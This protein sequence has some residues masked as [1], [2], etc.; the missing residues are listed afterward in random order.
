MLKKKTRQKKIYIFY[1]ALAL[2]FTEAH[3]NKGG[4]LKADAKAQKG[5]TAV[6]SKRDRT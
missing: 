5:S 2:G 4:A 1:S 6:H 3:R